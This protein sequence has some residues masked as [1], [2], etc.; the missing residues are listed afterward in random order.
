[1]LPKTRKLSFTE[2]YRIVFLKN[3]AKLLAKLGIKLTIQRQSHKMVKHTQTIRW[4]IPD[5]LFECVFD[6]FVG[7]A[8]KRLSDSKRELL[9]IRFYMFRIKNCSSST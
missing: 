7:L 2:F 3:F 1:M 8:L 6:H 5:E 9:I 4:Q